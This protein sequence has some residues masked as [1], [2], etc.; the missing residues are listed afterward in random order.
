MVAFPIVDIQYGEPELAPRRHASSS[1][2]F[3]Q[4]S[5]SLYESG[6]LRGHAQDAQHNVVQRGAETSGMAF[7]VPTNS[8]MVYTGVNDEAVRTSPSRHPQG[9]RDS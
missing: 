5:S 6:V 7:N 9:G 2:K 1:A 4:S 3:V 8:S